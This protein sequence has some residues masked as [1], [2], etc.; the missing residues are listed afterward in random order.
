ML[1]SISQAVSGR[2]DQETFS[3]PSIPSLVASDLFLLAVQTAFTFLPYFAYPEVAQKDI[4]MIGAIV[5]F[6]W[7]RRQ[8]N[9]LSVMR[10]FLLLGQ[11]IT[12]FAL[13]RTNAATAVRFGI[14]SSVLSLSGWCSVSRIGIGANEQLV[15]S[16]TEHGLR[17]VQ[18]DG[19]IRQVT[20]CEI[21]AMVEEDP[22]WKSVKSRL[23]RRSQ[24]PLQ[25]NSPSSSSS[26]EPEDV[27]LAVKLAAA[28]GTSTSS[29]A[30]AVKAVST[31]AICHSGASDEVL[32]T[33]LSV[34]RELKGGL[35]LGQSSSSAAWRMVACDIDRWREVASTA[36][37]PTENGG[38]L[39]L[40]DVGLM[41]LQRPSVFK[42]V[43][44]F[45]G[46]VALTPSMLTK[47]RATVAAARAT[48]TSAA[49]KDD[50][51]KK[52]NTKEQQNPGGWFV[53]RR[54]PYVDMEGEVNTSTAL[55]A[56]AIKLNLVVDT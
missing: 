11:L 43:G 38:I 42:F 24:G 7:G 26:P 9:L 37:V 30:G 48:T 14:L 55:S 5:L 19:R 15:V 32:Q 39:P 54:L 29:A 2:Q 36:S 16:G 31:L 27:A 53:V 25:S 3:F 17:K 45:R 49:V 50:K 40:F 22:Y 46:G 35:L 1:S 33:S 6:S 23:Q 47:A 13:V 51:D 44:G 21:A 4:L 18:Q 8:T 10:T 28:Q 41:S 34:S 20:S 52:D 12:F 56:R